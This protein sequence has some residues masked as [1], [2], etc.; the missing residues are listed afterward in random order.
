M[1][2]IDYFSGTK[3]SI[4]NYAKVTN[5]EIGLLGFL[6]FLSVVSGYI[7][8]DAF[9]GFGSNYFNNSIYNIVSF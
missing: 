7:F 3:S 1:V 4:I 8:K 9:A 2:F 6:G 5:L